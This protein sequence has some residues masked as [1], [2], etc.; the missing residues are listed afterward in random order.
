MWSIGTMAH[1][2]NQYCFH[3]WEWIADLRVLVDRYYACLCGHEELVQYLLASGKRGVIYFSCNIRGYSGSLI[4]FL[5][6]CCEATSPYKQF[7]I[8]W[9]EIIELLWICF[10]CRANG[11][12]FFAREIFFLKRELD[13]FNAVVFKLCDGFCACSPPS[14]PFQVL[15]QMCG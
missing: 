12:T 9:W 14:L 11:L 15:K 13:F 6:G 1:L 8:L 5:N 3:F 7:I 4:V 2:I 10:L